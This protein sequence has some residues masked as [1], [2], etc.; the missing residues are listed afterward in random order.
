MIVEDAYWIDPTSHEALELIID[1]IAGLRA[2]LILTYRPE[3]IT[4]WVSRPQVT[5]LTLN[6]H[7]AAERE[8]V[9]ERISGLAI[10][11]G[12]GRRLTA[13]LIPLAET[14]RITA[15]IYAKGA[16]A[17]PKTHIID[18]FIGKRYFLNML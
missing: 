13:T 16:Q 11:L 4:L 17:R 8:L 3:F 18:T 7:A 5:L 9:G 15:A 2:M 1:H 10:L 6:E 12:P 14:R